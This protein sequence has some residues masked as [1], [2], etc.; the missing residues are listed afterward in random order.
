V[1]EIEIRSARTKPSRRQEE[2]FIVKGRDLQA[3]A[4]AFA[5][6]RA[7]FG[8]ESVTSA[9]LCDSHLPER[10][11]RWMPL[12][13]PVVPLPGPGSMAAERP[14]AVRRILFKPTQIGPGSQN[15]CAMSEPFVVSGS[16]WG[17]DGEDAPFLRDYSFQHSPKGILWLF[18]DRL[19]GT[20]WVQGAVD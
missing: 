3:G 20:S 11:F 17:T 19:T 15:A 4:R 1:V 14:T 16:W 12:E 7:R 13:K 2:L 6:I 8:N 10:S 5:A 9:H 18:A